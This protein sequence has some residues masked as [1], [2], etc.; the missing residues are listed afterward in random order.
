V[1]ALNFLICNFQT[2]N[3]FFQVTTDD[4]TDPMCSSASPVQLHFEE[5]TSA[6]FKIKSGI[7]VTPCMVSVCKIL[8]A[9]F[10]IAYSDDLTI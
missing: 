6:A 8:N 5:I 9:L 7:L 4:I 10:Y 2:V 3:S 1:N